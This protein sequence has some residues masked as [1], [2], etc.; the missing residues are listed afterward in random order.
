MN[1][2]P[3]ASVHR[4]GVTAAGRRSADNAPSARIAPPTG[5]V[6]PPVKA[7]TPYASNRM[8]GVASPWRQSSAAITENAQPTSTA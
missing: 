7:A 1:T 6:A 8:P 3:A 4:S 5:N 2:I